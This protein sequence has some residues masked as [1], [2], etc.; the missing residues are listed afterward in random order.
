MQPCMSFQSRNSKPLHRVHVCLVVTCHLHLWQNDR[1]LLRATAVTGVEEIPKTS[2][3]RKLTLGKK[4]FPPHRR[5][6][7]LA[8]FRSRVRR[9]NHWAISAPLWVQSKFTSYLTVSHIDWNGH[10]NGY[11]NMTISHL[12]WNGYRNGYR[13][14]TVSRVVWNG[15]RNMTVLHLNWHGYRNWY[16][17]M[18]VSCID[19]NGYRNGYWNTSQHWKLTLEKKILPLGL[20]PA[21]FRSRVRRRRSTTELSSLT[22]MLWSCRPFSAA[23]N[24]TAPHVVRWDELKISVAKLSKLNSPIER[25]KKIRMS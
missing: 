25:K 16:R 24:N 21:T 2:Q 6:L 9:S 18:T 8:T 1:G 5:G 14:M 11:W 22:V 17:N 3:H 15:Y 13:N 20:K 10:Q 23:P 12:D 4:I 7:E 19:W